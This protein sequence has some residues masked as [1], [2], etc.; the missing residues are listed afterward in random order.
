MSPDHRRAAANAVAIPVMADGDTGFGN[1][2][3]TA[4]RQ[5]TTGTFARALRMGL[6]TPAAR[7]WAVISLQ[8]ALVAASPPPEATNRRVVSA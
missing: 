4:W 1:A 5:P 7:P 3:N 6:V 8:Y 2:V